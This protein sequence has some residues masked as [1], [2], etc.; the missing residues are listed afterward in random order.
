MATIEIA[1]G[2]TFTI[3]VTVDELQLL[4]KRDF[5]DKAGLMDTLITPGVGGL[6][7]AA[8]GPKRT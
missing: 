7:D 6:P 3:H 2:R 5:D 8:S 4:D 1:S